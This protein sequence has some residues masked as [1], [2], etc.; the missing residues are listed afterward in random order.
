MS[1]TTLKLIESIQQNYSKHKIGKV[2]PRQKKTKKIARKNKK[3]LG[4][5][6]GVLSGSRTGLILLDL[7]S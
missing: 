5:P 4:V 1:E 6:A 2:Y 3:S 7:E